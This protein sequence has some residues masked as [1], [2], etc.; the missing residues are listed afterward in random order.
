MMQTDLFENLESPQYKRFKLYHENN[1]EVFEY[2][3][4]YALRSIERG[5]KHLSAE[6]IFNIIRWETPI[7]A[8]GDDFKINNDFKPWYSRMFMAQYPQYEGFFRKR[9]S[10]AD[11]MYL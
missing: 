6:F 9:S 8:S 10:M 1:P 7:T 2:F 4:R 5:F 11:T 3:K